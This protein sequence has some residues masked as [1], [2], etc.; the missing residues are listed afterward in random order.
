MVLVFLLNKTLECLA[1]L[2]GPINFGCV[3]IY[4]ATDPSSSSEIHIFSFIVERKV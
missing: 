4:L 2:I 3:I 1:L